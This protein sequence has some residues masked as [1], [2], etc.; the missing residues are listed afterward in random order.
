[1]M[2]QRQPATL[3]GSRTILFAWMLPGQAPADL[4]FPGGALML[5]GVVLVRPG[6]L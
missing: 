5:A 1:M 3:L 4:R 2:R 6:G